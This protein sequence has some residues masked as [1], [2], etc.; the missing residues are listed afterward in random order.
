MRCL[1]SMEVQLRPLLVLETRLAALEVLSQ[2][3]DRH[4]PPTISQAD[5]PPCH[6]NEGRFARCRS[7]DDDD[8]LETVMCG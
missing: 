6:Q 2:D 4:P 1:E 7:A 3:K 8:V 5:P